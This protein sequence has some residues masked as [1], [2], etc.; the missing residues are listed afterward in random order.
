MMDG[1]HPGASEAEL[2]AAGYFKA[3]FLTRERVDTRPLAEPQ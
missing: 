1:G 3:E 2:V